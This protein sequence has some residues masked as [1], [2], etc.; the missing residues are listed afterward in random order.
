MIGSTSTRG[1]LLLTLLGL[2]V[3]ALAAPPPLVR[4]QKI[5]PKIRVELKY[6]T[7]DNAFKQRFYRSGVALLREPVARRLSRV[8]RR[9]EKQGLGLKVWDAYR[10]T[11]V[12]WAL[13]RAKPGTRYLSNP[14]KGGSK[15]SRGAAVDVTLVDR[16]GRELKLPTPHDEFSARAHRGATKGVTPLAQK[17]A[18]ILDAA[19]R[20]EGWIANKYEWWHFSDPNWRRYPLT[21]TPLPRDP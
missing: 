15:H 7:A 13:W 4:I 2:Q 5:D 10:P 8:Q 6:N 12:Q 1:L 11:S 18:R 21:D 20:A 3:C 19:M 9:L 16:D 17:N 14:A